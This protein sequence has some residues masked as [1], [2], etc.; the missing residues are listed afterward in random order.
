M[1]DD[2]IKA[3][4]SFAEQSR[5]LKIANY[6]THGDNDK[7]KQMVS[8][9]FKDICMFKIKYSGA[10][11]F[12]AFLLFFNTEFFSLTD[13][14]GIVSPS[15]NVED[16]NTNIK[17]REFEHIIS[18]YFKT[19]EHDRVLVNHTRDEIVKRFSLQFENE[20]KL[21]LE[22][23]NDVEIQ[24]KISRIIQNVS[25]PQPIKLSMDY[26]MT[27]SLEVELLSKSSRKIDP[28]DIDRY[29]DKDEKEKLDGIEKL[30]DDDGDPLD[31][32][33][34]KLILNADLVLSPIKGR[35]VSKLNKGDRIMVKLDT[36]NEKA[37]SLANAFNAYEDNKIKPIPG[38]I[39]SIKFSSEEGFKI[40]VNVAKGIYIKVVESE[41]N[42]KVALDKPPKEEVKVIEEKPS[43]FYLPIIISLVV[44]FFALLAILYIFVF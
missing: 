2:L 13:I 19:E 1:A 9:N 4:D 24:R 14:Y 36:N 15:F 37:L 39:V 17:W 32:K 11:G 18:E 44:I 22:N 26:E 16:I 30:E 38:E 25:G 27:S 33:D 10:S 5:R 29:K 40:Y 8:G 31:G 34:V 23:K 21:L 12:G 42:I 41:E 43:R 20:L 35:E 3:A 7:A 28:K 6:Y